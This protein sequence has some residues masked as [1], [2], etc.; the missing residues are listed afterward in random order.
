MSGFEKHDFYGILLKYL[1]L[2]NVKPKPRP[3]ANGSPIDVF[4]AYDEQP[5]I[6]ENRLFE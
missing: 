3:T 1:N 4:P 2:W 6:F 5:G